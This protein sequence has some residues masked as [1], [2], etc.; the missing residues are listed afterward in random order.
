MQ[1]KLSNGLLFGMLTLLSLQLNAQTQTLENVLT[2]K[3]SGTGPIIN[4]GINGYYTLYEL[5]KKTKGKSD[6]QLSVFDQ[7]LSPLSSKKFVMTSGTFSQE[8]TFNGEYLLFKFQNLTDKKY[9]YKMFDKNAK[10]VRSVSKPAYYMDYVAGADNVDQAENLHL[11]P[12]PGKGF[13]NYSTKNQKGKMSKTRYVIDFFPNDSSSTWQANTPATSDFYEYADYLGQAGNTLLSLVIKREGL[14]DKDLEE[15][16]LGTDLKTGKKLFEYKLEDPDH[17]VSTLNVVADEGS[18]FSIIGLYYEKDA[19][20]FKDKSM[21]LFAF[22]LDADGKVTSRKYVSWASDV[23]KFLPMT[24]KGKVKD[25]GFIF[26]HRFVKTADGSYFG[27]GEEYHREASAIGIAATV[28]ARGNGGTSVLKAVTGDL[29]VFKFDQGFA[30]QGVT[31]Y[32]KARSNV[33][34]PP[35][36]SMLSVRTTGLYMKSYGGF[37]YMFTQLSKDKTEFNSGYLD[38]ERT[39]GNKGWKFGSVNYSDGKL[40]N[41]KL[42]LNSEATWFRVFPGKPGYVMVAEYF[43]KKKQMEFRMEKLNY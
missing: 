40:A 38:Y 25:V 43:R 20:S 3:I 28:L 36:A 35:G 39:K 30:L 27:I 31:A 4:E 19:K 18:T 16:I 32:D 10:L 6:F 33:S 22:T 14:F 12:L 2:A 17:T 7:N 21:G 13:V 37:D 41:D 23:A 26:F 5:A 9:A 11:Y 24:E 42:A 34:L 15:H 29:Y 8:A 1:L